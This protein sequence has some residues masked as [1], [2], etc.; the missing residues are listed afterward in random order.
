MNTPYIRHLALLSIFLISFTAVRAGAADASPPNKIS[1]QGH[2]IDANGIPLGNANPRNFDVAFRIYDVAQGGT[3]LWAEQQTI[4]VDKGYFSVLLGEG[5]VIAS[6]PRPALSALFVGASASDRY[7]GITVSG[8]AA[9]PVEITPRLQLLPGPYSFLAENA[10]GLVT[11][12][13]QVLV[14]VATGTLQVS[15][16]VQV[17][18]ALTATSLAGNGA[19]ITQIDAGNVVSG[20]LNEARIG[21]LNAS[22]ITTGTLTRPVNT[23]GDVTAGGNIFTT[24]GMTA[25]GVIHAGSG[26]RITGSHFMEFGSGIS[27][28][29]VSAGKIGYGTFSS[30]NALDIVGAGTSGTT[31]RIKL[32]GEGGIEVAGRIGLGTTTPSGKL[33]VQGGSFDQIHI[34]NPNNKGWHIYS[35]DFGDSG[36]LI[37]YRATGGAAEVLWAQIN[38]SNGQYG[39][40]SDRRLKKD[41]VPL[42]GQLA[43]VLQLRPVSYRLKTQEDNARKSLGFIAQEVEPLFPEVVNEGPG[44]M[45]TL[46]YSDLV[47]VAIGSVQE[48]HQVVTQQKSEIDQLKQS[49]A[50]LQT[51]VKTL[52]DAK[53]IAAQ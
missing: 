42:K 16:P 44:G 14:N 4:T 41:I 17:D 1:Y 48:L 53:K 15:A 3:A 39:I 52:V 24:A 34:S 38:R 35:N 27:G 33:H 32:W 7:V 46:A 22:K 19:L 51:L 2:L 18:G 37:F 25:N 45:K 20:T 13:G 49:V 5:S 6:E 36:D 9:T 10:G 28:K 40:G 26:M 12:N 8:L 47:P 29:E 11:D 43:S 30:G 50:E 23:S 21:N 31:R